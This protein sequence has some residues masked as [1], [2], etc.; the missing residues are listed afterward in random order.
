MEVLK[1]TRKF[2]TDFSD[3]P[4]SHESTPLLLAIKCNN[5][6]VINVLLP[7]KPDVNKRNRRNE[8]PL[9][10]AALNDHDHIIR[11]ILKTS[12]CVCL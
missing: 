9:H 12:K 2:L 4:D 11:E 8:S 10:V 1:K 6:E 5:I 3:V 7:A